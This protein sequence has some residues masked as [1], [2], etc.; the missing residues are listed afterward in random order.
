MTPCRARSDDPVALERPVEP[1]TPASARHDGLRIA[2]AGG[3]FRDGLFPQA[4]TRSPRR[5]RAGVEREI[6]I[7]EAARARAAAYVI[8]ASEGARCTSSACARAR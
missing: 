1:V 6:E 4:Q 3:Y 5:R 8:T 2:V 7:P